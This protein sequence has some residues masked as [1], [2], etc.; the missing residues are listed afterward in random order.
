[1]KNAIYTLLITIAIITT[2]LYVKHDITSRLYPKAFQVVNVDEVHDNILLLDSTGN[3]WLY[4]GIEDWEVGDKA[5]AIM[6]N[7]NTLTIYDDAII[8]LHYTR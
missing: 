1:M 8:K 5:V 7:N 6:D 4:S 3:D 2:A